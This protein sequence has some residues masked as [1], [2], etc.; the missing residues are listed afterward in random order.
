M[1][2]RFTSAFI[3]R[4]VAAVLVLSAAILLN[5]APVLL[6]LPPMP[7]TNGTGLIDNS[8]EL[9]SRG[10]YGRL[11]IP[12]VGI[13]VGPFYVSAPTA[14]KQF[15]V[16]NLDSAAYFPVGGMDIAAD[17][18]TQGFSAIKKAVAGKTLAFIQTGKTVFVYRCISVERGQNTGT[19]LLDAQGNVVWARKEAQLCTYTCNMTWTDVT[20][21]L[22]TYIG[23]FDI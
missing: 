16:D 21:I 4:M 1:K 9:E 14:D 20:V 10:M 23:T 19:S 11:F 7:E 22:W 13:K 8:A 3:S 15:A 17:H 12:D 6:S 5:R 2:K 18:N